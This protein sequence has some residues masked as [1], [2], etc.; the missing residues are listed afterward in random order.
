MCN[1]R[2]AGADLKNSK[3]FERPYLGEKLTYERETN[4][5]LLDISRNTRS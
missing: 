4:A 5:I 3:P 1:A 2:V